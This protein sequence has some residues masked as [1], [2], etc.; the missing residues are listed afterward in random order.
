MSAMGA[1][2]LRPHE[3]LSMDIA[4]SHLCFWRTPLKRWVRIHIKPLSMKGCSKELLADYL[5]V[6]VCLPGLYLSLQ[7]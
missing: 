7:V 2:R 4:F 3:Y 1:S 5:C 6:C